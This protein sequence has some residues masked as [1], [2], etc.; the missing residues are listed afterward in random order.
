MPMAKF[1]QML[2]CSRGA[3]MVEFAFAGP[4]L[5]LLTFAFFE[6]SLMLFTQ[7]VLHYSAEQATR[8]AMVNLEQNNLDPNYL[9]A[10]KVK[11][12]D[13]AKQSFILIDQEKITNFNVDVIV[14]P[15]DNTKTVSIT[16]DYN[17]TMIMPYLS[18]STFTMTGKSESFLVQ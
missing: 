2:H 3:T 15:D 13:R 16:I 4:V 14:D 1:K 12:Q 9:A 17:Y 18:Q 11:I 8:F 7:G 10:A 6:F 5:L